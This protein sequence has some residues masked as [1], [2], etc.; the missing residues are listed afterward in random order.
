M[1]LRF[2]DIETEKRFR[3][4]LN[5]IND[6]VTVASPEGVF[7]YV[8]PS[9]KRIQGYEPHEMEGQSAF[10]FIHPEDISH[11]AKTTNSLVSG[12]YSGSVVF[13]G[14][15]KQGGYVWLE[16][17]GNVVFDKDGNL[18]EI[19]GCARDITDRILYER[20]LERK[21]ELMREQGRMNEKITQELLREKLFKESIIEYT[22]T[23]IAALDLDL[24]ITE[25]NPALEKITGIKKEGAI[26]RNWLNIYEGA[27]GTEAHNN[28]LRVLKGETIYMPEREFFTR[29]GY[30]S[31][32]LTPLKDD[33]GK[34]FGMVSLVTDITEHK[35]NQLML[36]EQK[37]FLRQITDHH[38]SI[39]YVYDVIAKKTLFVNRELTETLGYTIEDFG[40]DLEGFTFTIVHEED[41][42]IIK[43]RLK[44]FHTAGDDD[45]IDDEI[46]M[47]TSDGRWLWL[48]TRTIIFKR[49]PE[50]KVWQVLGNISDI[51]A[52][53]EAE[54][55][56]L[57]LRNT[58]DLLR[59][60]EEFIGIASHELKT[61]LT[62]IKAYTQLLQHSFDTLGDDSKKQF[63]ERAA[64]YVEKL[65]KLVEDLLD[66]S[67]IQAGRMIYNMNEF[68]ID[69]MVHECVE[70]Y[71]RIS[72]KHI[73][74]YSGESKLMVK[75]DRQRLEQVLTN[76]LSNA[77]KYSPAA[78][79]VLVHIA[80]E[81]N[82][83]RISVTDFGIGIPADKQ[84]HI[85]DRFYRVEGAPSYIPGLGIG[86]YISKEIVTRHKGGI[87][88]NSSKDQ[89][90]TF[91]F[92]I[93][94]V[95]HTVKK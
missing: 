72:A 9:C 19:H 17:T 34:I 77:V 87:T 88:V 1:S 43:A 46:R 70:N 10:D 90:T 29:H 74:T 45:L 64:T 26:G 86:L 67:K 16:A 61:P 12:E 66:I 7:L 20:E 14:K 95:S 91:S 44:K 15:K 59:K 81:Q 73:I 13:R 28:F 65:N 58:E 33:S 83:V 76:L 6:L 24:N 93:P 48:N 40:D 84:P 69:S 68:S 31:T 23:G 42:P 92:T 25:W 56:K 47:R 8:S 60:K 22:P 89:G 41:H 75:G 27:R 63:I 52:K 62:S 80:A 4:L 3:D 50:G 53:K 21:N 37:A 39:L 55:A 35:T 38:P 11:V 18:L 32:Y 30:Y 79:R 78:D 57:H 54:S 5:N 51:T 36:A 94:A 49:T 82:Q 71:Q 85:F 2:P